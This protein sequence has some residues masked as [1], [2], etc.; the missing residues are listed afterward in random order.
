MKH[1]SGRG[2]NHPKRSRPRATEYICIGRG[3]RPLHGRGPRRRGRGGR[4][5][6][7]AST[8]AAKRKAAANAR[9]GIAGKAQRKRRGRAKIKFVAKRHGFILADS[10]QAPHACPGYMGVNGQNTSLCVRANRQVTSQKL[11]SVDCRHGGRTQTAFETRRL[12][13][14]LKPC[15]RDRAGA[16]V[17][18]SRK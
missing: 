3:H 5:A 17:P 14:K 1:R 7:G 8:T 18:L 10:V 6:K 12:V 15:P 13:Q 16:K 11:W 2:R 9:R 4:R